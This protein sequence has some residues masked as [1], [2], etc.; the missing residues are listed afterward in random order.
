MTIKYINGDVL[1][2]DPNIKILIP[3]VCN[4]IG[5]MGAGVA[6]QIANKYPIVKDQYKSLK[7][8]QIGTVQIVKINDNLSIA[9]MIA[10]KGLISQD[11]SIPLVYSSLVK[12]MLYIRDNVDISYNI[13][14]PKF[15]SG[16]AGGN[17]KIIEILVDRIW[18]KF[19]VE[20]Y[21]L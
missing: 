15:G 13:H 2:I 7:E 21:E 20:L 11:N 4:D 6:K 18:S 9:N 10:Q 3:H 8:Y 19:V 12:C 5:V 16:L 17:W 14:C 1:K